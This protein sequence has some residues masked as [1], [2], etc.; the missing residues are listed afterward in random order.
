MGGEQVA[1]IDVANICAFWF[2]YEDRGGEVVSMWRRC[3]E[4]LGRVVWVDGIRFIFV[5]ERRVGI[6]RI[7]LSRDD[8]MGADGNHS[9]IVIRT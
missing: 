1:G 5:G 9:C 3:D 8:W 7:M 4:G 2:R 6:L